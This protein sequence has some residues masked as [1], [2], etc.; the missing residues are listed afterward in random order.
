MMKMMK[1]EEQKNN[2]HHEDQYSSRNTGVNSRMSDQHHK[3]MQSMMFGADIKER[4]RQSLMKIKPYET[5]NT[6]TDGTLEGSMKKS[7]NLYRTLKSED[8]M[9]NNEEVNRELHDALQ[10]IRSNISS[11]AESPNVIKKAH[12]IKQGTP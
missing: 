1:M 3:K 5:H 2:P 6:N 7:N 4:M 12:T 10:N 9:R 8:K 11:N